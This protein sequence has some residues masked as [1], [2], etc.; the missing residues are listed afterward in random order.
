MYLYIKYNNMFL[1]KKSKSS[2]RPGLPKP[3]EKVQAV[4]PV[5]E[6]KE[7]KPKVIRKAPA[8]KEKAE[9][10]PVVETENNEVKIINEDGQ[11]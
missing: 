11:Q 7:E 10:K 8:K 2:L 5:E 4:A 3:V 9:P 1:H 6:K